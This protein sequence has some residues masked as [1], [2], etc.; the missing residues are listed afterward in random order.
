[1]S[2]NNSNKKTKTLAIKMGISLGL[3]VI[4]GLILMFLR[5]SLLNS[6]YSYV[7]D[8]INRLLFQD[9]SVPEGKNSIGLF[10]I[11][12]QLFINALQLVIVPL[13]FSSIALSMC[14]I[15]DNKKFGRIAGKTVSN[16]F[17]MYLLALALACVLGL[18][19]HNLGMFKVEISN[20]ASSQITDSNSNPLMI[21]L[22]AI[23]N[24]FLS[25]F[26]TNSKVLSIV[27]LAI[28]TGIC[29]NKL[30]NKILVIKSILQDINSI[31]SEFLS[32]IINKF[33]PIAI[34]ILIS[35]TF[36]IYGVEHL[37][38]AISYMIVTT[39]G[40]LIFF[41]LGYPLYIYIKTKLN[42]FIF[43]KKMSKVALLGISASSSAAALSLNEKTCEEELGINKEI[44]SFTLP[45]GMTINM[46]G[47]AIMQVIATVF[48][49]SSAG[50][51]INTFDII[52]IS[53]L[54]LMASIGTPS[55]PGSSTIILFSILTGMGY[56]NESSLI[57][58]SL[59][60]AINRPMDMLV[61][62]LNVVGDAAT[63]LIVSK[64]ENNL[65][66]NIYKKQSLK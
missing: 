50:Y 13:I 47:T 8:I 6:S 39:I 60:I 20:I 31:V 58:Y 26:T 12:G 23:P 64:S 15:K 57:A 9:I 2:N 34:F 21:I 45:L 36:A 38:P 17:I 61:T 49:A 32:F 55:I 30:D 37:K 11:L 46:N 53:F 51:N 40:C 56:N 48:I 42:P 27:F 63:A 7:W 62:A 66:E 3:G 1:M 4:V 19:A 41:T 52:L 10:Y 14:Q 29:I 25:V 33:S 44:I 43:I 59:I 54:T 24:N 28:I 35:R 22:D 18:I 16:F 65:D 5:E